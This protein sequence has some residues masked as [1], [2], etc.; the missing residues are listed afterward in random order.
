MRP[1]PTLYVRALKKMMIDLN[2]MYK[3]YFWRRSSD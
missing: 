1:I 3:D 2:C